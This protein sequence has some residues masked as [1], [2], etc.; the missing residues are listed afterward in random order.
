MEEFV[1]LRPK[2]YAFMCTGK[3]DKNVLNHVEPVDK[4]TAEGVKRKVKH[5]H[6]RFEHYLVVL[7]SF[8]SSV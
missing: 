8:E 7:H 5:D 2:C 1:G 6:L 4:K 3:V